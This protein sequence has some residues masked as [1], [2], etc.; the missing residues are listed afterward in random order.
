ML[1]LLASRELGIDSPARV[2]DAES[3]L[4]AHSLDLSK[5]HDF[6]KI[7]RGGINS[8]DLDPIESR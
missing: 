6:Q 2:F 7:H 1:N 8:L 5:Y 3:T 4:L